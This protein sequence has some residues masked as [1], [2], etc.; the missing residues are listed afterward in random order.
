MARRLQV[1]R[2]IAH[3]PRVLFLDE[4]TAGLDPQS[5]IALWEIVGEMRER[6]GLTVI[7]TTHHMEEADELCDRVAV[8][9]HGK[10]LVCDA[11]SHLKRSLGAGTVIE[12]RLE[13]PPGDLPDVLAGL[14]G[15]VSADPTDE[16]V[17][18]LASTANGLLPRI[19]EAAQ[20]HGLSDVSVTEPTLETVLVQLT[21]RELR[22]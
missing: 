15:V 18:V 11:P 17:R 14:E 16:G 8:I 19:V 22:E 20:G 2:A 7:L 21:G 3:R 6:E 13:E 9:D 4:P 1:A 10:I 5:R 12:L